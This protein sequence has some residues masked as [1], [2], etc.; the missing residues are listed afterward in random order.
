MKVVQ[1]AT[2]MGVETMPTTDERRDTVRGSRLVEAEGE[3]AEKG[4]P[5]I[6]A[7]LLVVAVWI[8]GCATCRAVVVEIKYRAR[9]K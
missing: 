1:S 9:D 6:Y 8:K 7:S 4:A 3:W 2:A 5:F